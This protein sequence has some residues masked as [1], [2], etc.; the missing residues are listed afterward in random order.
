MIH[1]AFGLDTRPSDVPSPLPGYKYGPKYRIPLRR[2]AQTALYML[3]G[4]PRNLGADFA[5]LA[6][7]MPLSPI[8]K[9]TEH[10]PPRGPF[11]VVGNHYERPQLWMA[12]SALVT[13]RAV[14]ERTGHPVHWVAITEWHDYRLY[15]IPIPPW[16]TR[17]VFIRFHRTFGFISMAPE[18]ASAEERARGIR[19]ALRII[20]EGGIIGI[21]PEGT[22]GPTPVMLPARAGTGL[23]LLTLCQGDAPILPV[24]VFE[25][26]QRLIIHFGEPFHLVADPRLSRDQQDHRARQHVMTAVAALLPPI[27][28][29]PYNTQAEDQRSQAQQQTG[30]HP[31]YG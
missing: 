10:I 22:V 17:F 28:R 7:D 14:Y 12:W 25:H 31:C 19:Q 3:I 4:K 5:I 26:E 16:L 1:M 20:R 2:L 15:G 13:G 27:L 9:G 30:E 11:V 8:V 21:F 18:T 24:G 29:G 23:F 6:P